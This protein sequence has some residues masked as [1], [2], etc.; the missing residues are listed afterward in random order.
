MLF[1]SILKYSWLYVCYVKTITH[2]S[3]FRPPPGLNETDVPLLSALAPG[4]LRN[5]SRAGHV[6]SRG[7]AVH[8]R[9]VTCPG[10]H[11]AGE[12]VAIRPVC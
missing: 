11:A 7:S 4:R 8:R 5:T 12:P 9:H 10:R 1:V 2:E 6:M 3:T